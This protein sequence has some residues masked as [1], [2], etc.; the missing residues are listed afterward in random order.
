MN[1]G[2]AVC[3]GRQLRRSSTH[4]VHRACGHRTVALVAQHIDVRHI[5][6]PGVLRTMGS[7]APHAPLRLDRNMLKH[8][9]PAR[10]HM[11]LGADK[12]LIGG[13]LQVALLE[14][15]MDVMAITASDRAFLHR[16][17]ERHSERSFDVT[18]ALE[19]KHRFGGLE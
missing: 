2:V 10:L 13:G 9:R 14:S 3:A 6:Q 19:A 18:V 12:V 15:T 1:H 4:T 16:M 17:V 11:A 8:E 7:M 5:Q